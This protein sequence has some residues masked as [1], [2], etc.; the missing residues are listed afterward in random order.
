L[1]SGERRL[2]QGSGAVSPLRLIFPAITSAG[3]ARRLVRRCWGGW[4]V[5]LPP[6]AIVVLALIGVIVEGQADLAIWVV[7]L[8]LVLLTLLGLFFCQRLFARAAPWAA[9]VLLCGA[10]LYL[11]T[12][13]IFVVDAA[14]GVGFWRWIWLILTLFALLSLVNAIRGCRGLRYFNRADVIAAPFLGDGPSPGP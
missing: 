1:F 11:S 6:V 4:Y 9:W 13:V 5:M 10:V 12:V 14:N 7:I 3:D 2:R 8:I